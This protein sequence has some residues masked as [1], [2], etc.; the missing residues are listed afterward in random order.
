MQSGIENP[1]DFDAAARLV[2][3]SAEP[4]LFEPIRAA[5]QT[6]ARLHSSRLHDELVARLSQESDLSEGLIRF[7]SHLMALIPARGVALWL[8]GQYLSLGEAPPAADIAALA[9]WLESSNR[10]DVFRTNAL[11]DVYPPAV[12]FA[13]LVNAVLAFPLSPAPADYLMWFRQVAPGAATEPSQRPWQP[14]DMEAAERL[15]ASLC[16]VVRR[17]I[18]GIARERKSARLLQEQLMRQVD[19]GLHRSK[20]ATQTLQEETRRRVAVEADLSQLLRRTVEDQEAERL[21]ISRELHDTLGQTLTLLQLA[22]D[23][24]GRNTADDVMAQARVA[25]LKSLTVDL[26]R[27]VRQ[28]AWEIRPPAL[29][30][31][32]IEAAIRHLLEV[33]SEKSRID[34]ELHIT[35]GDA[36]LPPA[37]ETTL[38]RVLQEALTNIV[39]HAAAKHVGIVLRRG[40]DNL[41]MIVE[42][43]GCGFA[44]P[45]AGPPRA[46]LGLLG[47]RERLSLVD[48]TLEIESARGKG[49]ALF[50]RI[51][52]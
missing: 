20:D 42:D 26:G 2:P 28:L 49:T 45:E 46:R 5:R 33:W 29:D 36:R 34:L 9:A 52:L 31:I 13:P 16:G 51:P 47:I 37:V 4:A 6:E 8:R 17:R 32:G 38:Y 1:T 10:T 18:E 48:G 3:R 12:A 40:A 50:A 44:D 35:L 15:R 24:I 19:I 25:E 43:D 21:R 22:V 14:N 7:R 11:V 39:R 27:Q 30:D 41:T 23:D